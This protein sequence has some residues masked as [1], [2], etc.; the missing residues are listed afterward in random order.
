MRLGKGTPL[1]SKE[2]LGWAGLNKFGRSM[3]LDTEHLCILVSGSLGTL[4]S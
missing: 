1:W 3:Q 4:E 2:A